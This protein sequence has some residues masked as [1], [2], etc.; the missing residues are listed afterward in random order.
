MLLLIGGYLLSYDYAMVVIRERMDF[1]AA[2]RA[3]WPGKLGTAVYRQ[4]TAAADWRLAPLVDNPWCQP[5]VTLNRSWID[6]PEIRLIQRQGIEFVAPQQLAAGWYG[7][8][9]VLFPGEEQGSDLYRMFDQRRA[10]ERVESGNSV[11]V[12]RRVMDQSGSAAD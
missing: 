1:A 8:E 4:S 9:T 3:D 5:Y 6:D 11:R 12:F 7:V 2:S 10:W